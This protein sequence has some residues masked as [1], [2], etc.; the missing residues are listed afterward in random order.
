MG[1]IIQAF[2]LFFSLFRIR[3]VCIHYLCV[4]LLVLNIL[5][6]CDT[7]MVNSI[8]VNELH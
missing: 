8:I 3:R 2:L 1:S 7:L 6:V 4:S 5:F